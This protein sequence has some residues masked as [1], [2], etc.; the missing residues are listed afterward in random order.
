MKKLIIGA[1]AAAAMLLIAMPVGAAKP[2]PAT[3]ETIQ[4]G[5]LKASDNTTINTGY[6]QWGYNYQA[7][8]FNG[9]YQNN[10]RTGTPVNEGDRLMMKW[11][12]TWLSNQDCNDDGKLDRPASYRGSGAWLT[13]HATGTYKGSWSVLGTWKWLVLNTYEH[14]MTITNQ[15]PDGTFTGIGGYPAGHDPYN[16]AGE[17][18]EAITGK[19][20]GNKIT[21]TTTYAGW[22]YSVKVSGTIAD[23]G[24]ISGTD[25]WG[26]SSTYGNATQNTC[27][28]SDFVKIVAVPTDAKLI[29]GM[30]YTAGNIKIGPVAW[31]DFAIIQEISDNPCGKEDLGLLNF[32]SQLRSGLGNW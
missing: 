8:M 23:D 11:N 24:S 29:D 21:F 19:V 4:S 1:A 9:W 25:P 16:S 15:N 10:T 17:T 22:P 7:H 27:S 6:D 31:G 5:N 14:D 12:D 2:S 30:W 13:N 26:W 3:C 20:E 18:T 32:K 28:W